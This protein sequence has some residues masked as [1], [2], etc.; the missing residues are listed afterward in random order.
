MPL[1]Q[2]DLQK[3]ENPETL[4][5]ILDT[6]HECVVEAFDIPPK[7]RYQIVNQHDPEELILLD[8]GLGFERTNRQIVIR[9]TSKQ[10]TQ[11]KKEKLYELLAQ[12][13]E[14]ECSIPPKDLLISIVE[15]GDADWSFGF[16]RAQFLTGEL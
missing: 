7:D 8:T 4:R 13:L 16:G 9:V 1:I 3:Q 14:S 5:H 10:R 12:Q 11:D 6:I 2:V 15:N